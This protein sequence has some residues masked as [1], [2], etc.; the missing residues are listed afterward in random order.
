M[1]NGNILSYKG[2]YT[3]IVFDSEIRMMTG[4]I[5]DINDLIYFES[6]DAE[7]IINKFHEAV[8]DYLDFCKEKN[9]EPDKAY[10]GTFNVRIDTDLHKKISQY[11]F[12]NNKSL[13]AAVEE[14]IRYFIEYKP[15]KIVEQV[16]EGITSSFLFLSDYNRTISKNWNQIMKEQ[17]LQG[18]GSASNF[19]YEN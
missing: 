18:T 4:I 15:Y 13:N 11:A 19:C 12:L 16:K 17:V 10:K 7:S 2:Y 14:S 8:N 3:K 9:I 6:K 5:E 1:E